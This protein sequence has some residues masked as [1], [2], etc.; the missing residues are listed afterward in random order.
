MGTRGD[1]SA[2]CAQVEEA[3]DGPS[4]QTIHQSEERFRKS[5]YKIRALCIDIPRF[6]DIEFA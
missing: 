4:F 5:F 3:H 1:F 2:Y 6:V